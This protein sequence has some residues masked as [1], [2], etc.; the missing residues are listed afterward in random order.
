MYNYIGR[1]VE[2]N[3]IINI[4]LKLA[5]SYTI[6]CFLLNN[7]I[8]TYQHFHIIY[9]SEILG[10]LLKIIIGKVTLFLTFGRHNQRYKKV[11]STKTTILR[12]FVCLLGRFTPNFQ[13]IYSFPYKFL[14]QNHYVAFFTRLTAIRNNPKCLTTSSQCGNHTDCFTYAVKLPSVAILKLYW[15]T[16]YLQLQIVFHAWFRYGLEQYITSYRRNQLLVK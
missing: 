14:I 7:L 15:K 4:K 11:K 9:F 6:Y 10:M 3:T 2:K 1:H 5:N 12:K 13:R 8:P 16:R